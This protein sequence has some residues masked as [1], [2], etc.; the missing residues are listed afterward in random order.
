MWRYWN[1]SVSLSSFSINTSVDLL[2]QFFNSRKIFFFMHEHLHCFYFLSDSMSDWSSFKLVKHLLL[3]VILQWPV[4][5][6]SA[7]T[8]K[9]FTVH[10]F[11]DDI[12]LLC[13]CNSIK[14]LN[15]LSLN[16]KKTEMVIFKTKQKKFEGDLKIKLVVEDYIQ[17]S[18]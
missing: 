14:K 12:N 7:E 17:G 13:L 2:T 9:F 8:I 3:S 11:A 6:S 16:V 4:L 18:K 15:K 1:F 10:H 5:I